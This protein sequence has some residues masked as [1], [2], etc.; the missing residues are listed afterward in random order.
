[1]YRMTGK[2]FQAQGTGR[3]RVTDRARAGTKKR[4]MGLLSI[5]AGVGKQPLQAGCRGLHIYF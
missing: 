3:A 5:L 2:A 4:Q 1:M